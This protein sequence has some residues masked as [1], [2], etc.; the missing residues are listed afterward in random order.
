MF[1]IKRQVNANNWQGIVNAIQRVVF[2][3]LLIVTTPVVLCVLLS[4]CVMALETLSPEQ[5][6]TTL[7]TIS[8]SVSSGEKAAEHP[9]YEQGSKMGFAIDG[10]FGKELVLTRGTTY[11]FDVNT[12]VKHDFYFSTAAKGWGARAVTE[13]ISKQFIYK[14]KVRFTPNKAT[15]ERVFYACRNHKFMGGLIHVI[16]EGESV[17]L[18]D[19]KYYSELSNATA[20]VSES[21]IKKKLAL[22]K[23]MLVGQAAKRIEYG[24]DS[25]AKGLLAKAAVEILASEAELEAGNKQEAFDAIES[26]LANTQAAI[27]M[28][29]SETSVIDH[30]ARYVEQLKQIL[31]Y[32]DSYIQQYNQAKKKGDKP[33]DT[34]LTPKTLQMMIEGAAALSAKGDYVAANKVLNN[35]QGL[36]TAA[37]ANIFEGER[38]LYDK[39]FDTEEEEYN[40]ELA[41]YESYE[42]L[43]PIAIEMR[44]PS[45]W[46]V[47]LMNRYT[48]KSKTITEEAKQFARNNDYATAILGLQEATRQLQRALV[49]AGVR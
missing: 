22:A 39:S 31:I 24:S 21:E 1:L 2:Q 27:N 36:V 15:P 14:G 17:V 18:G 4:E 32:K 9:F 26:A 38:V 35:A 8:F 29:P 34:Q 23:Q 49:S 10:V 47:R 33:L 48:E 6:H 30:Q 41:R 46:T 13:G 44:R 3:R 37:L 43:I 5:S 40:Y 45:E 16:N 28:L 42:N 7:E 11:V 25:S 20:S 19:P 12:S